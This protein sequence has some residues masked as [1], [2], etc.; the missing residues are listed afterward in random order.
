G[1]LAL[2]RCESPLRLGAS[3][4]VPR[5]IDCLGRRTVRMLGA[6]FALQAAAFRSAVPSRVR[7]LAWGDLPPGITVSQFLVRTEWQGR[8][9]EIR[10]IGT[11]ILAADAP[12]CADNRGPG[13]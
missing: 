9:G 3:R 7:V 10:G 12:D 8:I 6:G 5:R 11:R 4:R 2:R 13:K 1:W